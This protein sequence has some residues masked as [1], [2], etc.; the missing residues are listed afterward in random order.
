VTNSMEPGNRDEVDGLQQVLE[1]INLRADRQ[2]PSDRILSDTLLKMRRAAETR[3]SSIKTFL[4]R[5][6]T[7]TLTQKIAAAFVITLGGLTLWFVLSLLG[8][9]GA[10]S[11]A[12]VA[13]EIRAAHTISW[14]S[15]VSGGAAT[16]PVIM[17]TLCME[18]GH[19]R[20]E[21]PNGMGV[22]IMDKTTGKTLML[23]TAAKTA[24]ILEIKTPGAAPNPTQDPEAYFQ[25]LAEQHGEPI[26]DRQ[27]GN[28]KAKG[29]RIESFGYPTSLW[30]D[31]NTKLPLMVESACTFGQQ[32]MKV[33]MTDF[34]FDAPMD[35]SQFSLQPPP[36]YTVTEAKPMVV[37]ADLEQNVITL[38]RYY[39]S[40][41]G[42]KFPASLTD[43]DDLSKFVGQHDS[44]KNSQL[45]DDS[46]NAAVASG[47]LMVRLGR[48][49]QGTDYDYTPQGVKLGD[50]EK[51]L[52]WYHD[53]DTQGYRA[54][55]GDLHAAD[56]A[57]ADVPVRR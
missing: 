17:K 40:K 16:Q 1:A 3:T 2:E 41:S 49:K 57:A 12:D 26:E 39:S 55:F 44:G 31:P 32:Q 30:V 53:K 24:Q 37:N 23:T 27:I 5:I 18:P 38:L 56:I 47:E 46:E 4:F 48:L 43:I 9:F 50:A 34:V 10:V 7:M 25:S 45:D 14:T 20:I 54:I 6:T 28:I 8:G 13:Q 52:F 15:K 21:F 22:M 33:V 29:F 42:G 11:F 19:V 35:E 36:G 51:R